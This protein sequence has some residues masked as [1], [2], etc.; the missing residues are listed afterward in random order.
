MSISGESLLISIGNLTGK[1][2]QVLPALT[3]LSEKV[4]NIYSKHESLYNEVRL[5]KESINSSY[6]E[7]KKSIEKENDKIRQ[8]NEGF[9][10]QVTSKLSS[11]A[12]EF[13]SI[14]SKL[15][16]LEKDYTLITK[17]ISVVK[18]SDSEDKKERW[19]LLLLVASSILSTASAIITSFVLAKISNP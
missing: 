4:S 1:M 15:E 16:E 8:V 5:F 12:L 10:E 2:E 14:K 6:A 11:G 7:N 13:L 3:V 9:K 18:Q 19:K 17:S